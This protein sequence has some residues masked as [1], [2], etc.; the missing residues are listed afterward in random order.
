MQVWEQSFH[1]YSILQQKNISI[2]S[3]I[4]YLGSG[5]YFVAYLET[6]YQTCYHMVYQQEVLGTYNL[7]FL[8]PGKGRNIVVRTRSHMYKKGKKKYLITYR[9]CQII[10]SQYFCKPKVTCI[11]RFGSASLPGLQNKYIKCCTFPE[12]KLRTE[13]YSLVSGN[14]NIGALKQISSFSIHYHHTLKD[15]YHYMLQMRCSYWPSH[16]GGECDLHAS[17]LEPLGAV[18]ATC[19]AS[20]KSENRVDCIPR[21]NKL[22][23]PKWK[24]GKNRTSSEK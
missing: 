23:M 14:K 20:A 18:R 21:H 12:T 8:P 4:F 9:R 6:K 16:L 2:E 17:N 24:Q 5:K 3:H 1:I 10:R 11:I 13:S 19:K 15:S 22:K 7:V